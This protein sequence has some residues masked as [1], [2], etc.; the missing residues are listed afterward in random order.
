MQFNPLFPDSTVNGEEFCGPVAPV[1]GS[2]MVA[3][4]V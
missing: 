4:I 3:L 2:L 1:V